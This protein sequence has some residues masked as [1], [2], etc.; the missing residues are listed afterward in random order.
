MNPQV[1]SEVIPAARSSEGARRRSPQSRLM[2]P[3]SHGYKT[4]ADIKPDFLETQ[5][6]SRVRGREDTC[7][8]TIGQ[9]VFY[10]KAE[11]TPLSLP[12]AVKKLSKI[13]VT[14]QVLKK[15]N[16]FFLCLNVLSAVDQPVV[17]FNPERTDKAS[18]LLCHSCQ[19][20]S[21]T[22]SLLLL[23]SHNDRGYSF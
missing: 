13:P 11:V 7:K 9:S 22:T 1:G 21:T 12:G 10:Q 19:L 17:C 8:H 23:S 14:S 6:R 20:L 5:Q 3:H 4:D 16:L 15:G 18:L 2:R